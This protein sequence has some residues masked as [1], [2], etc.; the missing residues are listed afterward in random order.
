MNITLKT[1]EMVQAFTLWLRNANLEATEETAIQ[2]L[3]GEDG[4]IGATITG[5]RMGTAKVITEEDF[6]AALHTTAKAAAASVAASMA[7]VP[8]TAPVTGSSLVALPVAA[9]LPSPP[10]TVSPSDPSLWAPVSR[11]N[12]G[13]ASANGKPS[14]S[15]L[16]NVL[17]YNGPP[18]LREFED[19]DDPSGRTK[20]VIDAGRFKIAP[21]KKVPFTGPRGE[22]LP[23]NTDYTEPME[24]NDDSP[25]D[26]E[27]PIV[28]SPMEEDE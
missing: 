3:Q 15:V 26:E 5:I 1:P 4:E 18:L 16:E 8:T 13:E 25:A 9:T 27:E 12:D 10:P 14:T 17:R 20:I 7:T 24:G 11:S 23:P 28:S 22:S 19:A 21:V 2:L 6:Q